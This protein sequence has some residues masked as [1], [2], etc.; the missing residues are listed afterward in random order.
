MEIIFR[1]LWA[2]L[3]TLLLPLSAL[4]IWPVAELGVVDEWS[5]TKTVQVL[6]ETGHIVYNGWATAMVGWMFYLG[7]VFV[8]LFGFSFTSVRLSMLV[9]SM[10]TVFL[11]HRTM[12]RCGIN[13]WNA[14]LGTITFALSPLFLP[15]AI[16]FMTDV[17][18][19]FCIVVCLYACVRALEADTDG[20]ALAWLC[21]AAVS[22]TLGG[23]VRQ[24]AWLGLLVMVPSTLWLLRKRSH[25][26]AV[27]I[28]VYVACV[29]FIFGA[30]RWFHQQL[31]SVPEELI[32][33]KLNVR[34]LLDVFDFLAAG[35]LE[36]PF[37]L[38]PLLL[39]FVPAV[40]LRDRKT[41]KVLA[42]T[43]LFF[44]MF[45]WLQAVLY[46]NWLVPFIGTYGDY[47]SIYGIIASSPLHGR[48]PVVLGSGIRLVWTIVMALALAGFITTLLRRN[49]RTALTSKQSSGVS[50]QSLGVLLVPVTLAYFGL[51]VPRAASAVLY[52][53]YLLVPFF[54]AMIPMLRYYQER[55]Q[56]RLPVATLIPI[57]LYAFFAIAGT[58]DSFVRFRAYL[59][60]I[61]ELQSARVPPTEIDGGLEYNGWIQIERT[62]YV[63]DPKIHALPTD[64]FKSIAKERFGI[65]PSI[66]IDPFSGDSFRYAMAKFPDACLGPAGFAPVTYRTWLSPHLNTIYI[67]K[68]GQP[69][70]SDETRAK[71]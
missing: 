26:L 43:V 21:F 47:V 70:G 12:V 8:K 11:V 9:V 20:A 48:T 19:L 23:T 18:G 4:I 2:V 38:L 13:D 15:I 27:G 71:N 7:A 44:V 45:S 17:P 36:I 60:V 24:I 54:L 49:Q 65:C 42:A 61:Q 3:C 67:V 51:L 58:H 68:V 33:G 28:P 6:A 30:M 40:S 16:N 41:W 55:V 69:D 57:G 56:L 32:R 35:V 29:A 39:F 50:W 22:N 14:T 63:N 59:A 37:L 62:G 25:F 1:R 5:Y 31:Y 52:D 10:A 46:R 66:W 64:H 34:A 53:R